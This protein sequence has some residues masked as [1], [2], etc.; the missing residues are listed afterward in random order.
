MDKVVFQKAWY[1][2]I[3]EDS[4]NEF[5]SQEIAYILYAAA[6]YSFFGKKVNLGE[7]F[8]EE[9]KHLNIAMPNIYSQ[10]D[11]IVDYGVAQGQRNQ[12]YNNEAIRELAS[13]G[14]TQKE[15]CLK[16]G[17]DVSKSKALS[18]NVGYKEGRAIYLKKERK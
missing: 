18:S 6:M 5:S 16:L 9:F 15:I 14:L 1:D 13:Q 8:G 7:E 17:Y 2:A 10:I 12:K 3:M 11:N 4:F